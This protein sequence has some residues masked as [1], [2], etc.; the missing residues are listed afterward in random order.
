M[1]GTVTF[2]ETFPTCQWVYDSA[3]SDGSSIVVSW[4][5]L[6]ASSAWT[7]YA[8][9]DL[10]PTAPSPPNAVPTLQA[11][12]TYSNGDPNPIWFGGFDQQG[13]A[14]YIDAMTA[15]NL[16]N[17]Y[18][19]YG[20]GASMSAPTTVVRTD[21]DHLAVQQYVSNLSVDGISASAHPTFDLVL[22]DGDAGWFAWMDDIEPNV[23]ESFID[24][25]LTDITGLITLFV[26]QDLE[27]LGY[28]ILPNLRSICASIPPQA[29]FL[30]AVPCFAAPPGVEGD[31]ESPLLRGSYAGG[32]TACNVAVVGESP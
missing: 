6:R 23:D 7:S 12:G 29:G 30:P 18:N 3:A 31:P 14:S 27:S 17:P 15:N 20:W 26:Q 5:Q 11:N 16:R 25:V 32:L 21:D 1:N 9:T 2:S 10:S 24:S 22:Q 8:P 13:L 4:L 28:A 19:A